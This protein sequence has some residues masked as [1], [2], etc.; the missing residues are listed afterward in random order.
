MKIDAI[1]RIALV[2]NLLML[3]AVM[4]GQYANPVLNKD[5]PDPSVVRAPDG[6]FCVYLFISRA[7]S[8]RDGDLRVRLS[9][10]QLVPPL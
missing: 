3:A 2:V 9:I 6:Q 8:P 5:M 10:A 4:R 7:T 1:K